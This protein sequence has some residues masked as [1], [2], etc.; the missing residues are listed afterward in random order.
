M[1]RHLAR[2]PSSFIG[3]DPAA[4][5]N[6]RFEICNRADEH[7]VILVSHGVPLEFSQADPVAKAWYSK[8]LKWKNTCTIAKDVVLDKRLNLTLPAEAFCDICGLV[9]CCDEGK[10]LDVWKHIGDRRRCKG[11]C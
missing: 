2:E 7:V 1:R 11:G 5:V 4:V 9:G 3:L 8:C 10:A 6:T